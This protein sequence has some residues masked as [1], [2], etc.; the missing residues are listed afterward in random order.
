MKKYIKS[1]YTFFFERDNFFFIYNSRTNNF[2]SLDI[3][4]RKII[5]DFLKVEKIESL[6]FINELIE[7]KI[8]VKPGEDDEYVNELTI[9]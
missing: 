8:L 9:L 5:E 6:D 1:R 2:Y 7:K 3:E 4:G